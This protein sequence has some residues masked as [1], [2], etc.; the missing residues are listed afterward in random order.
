[1]SDGNFLV[2]TV[3]QFLAEQTVVFNVVDGFKI[4][5]RKQC[6]YDEENCGLKWVA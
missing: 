5:Y 2:L 1:M 3:W 6:L 4:K